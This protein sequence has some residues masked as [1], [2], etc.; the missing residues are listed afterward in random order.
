MLV[1]PTNPKI[2]KMDKKEILCY[3]IS[4]MYSFSTKFYKQSIIQSEE[5]IGFNKQ[6]TKGMITYTWMHIA[7][8][9]FTSN[10]ENIPFHQIDGIKIY[11][12]KIHTD[13]PQSHLKR[14][15]RIVSEQINMQKR[16]HLITHTIK[17]PWIQPE[18]YRL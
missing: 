10:F 12:N 17:E 9:L 14:K 3:S 2:K 1:F 13:K 11:L 8:I 4:W 5:I 16:M 7:L 15:K 18:N 6:K